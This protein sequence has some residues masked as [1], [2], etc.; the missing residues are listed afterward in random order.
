MDKA[1]RKEK[2][3]AAAVASPNNLLH[4]NEAVEATDTSVQRDPF[5]RKYVDGRSIVVL[6]RAK[7]KECFR[8]FDPRQ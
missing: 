8:C 7:A 1:A 4:D 6:L 3:G 5:R 2:K